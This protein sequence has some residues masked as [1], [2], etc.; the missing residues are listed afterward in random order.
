VL[1][2]RTV[3]GIFP[4]ACAAVLVD[5]YHLGADDAAIYVPA[6]KQASDPSLY[7]FGREFFQTQAGWSIVPKL[8]GGSSRLTHMPVDLAIFLWHIASI[9]LFLLAAW[10]LLSVCFES[11]P[12]RWGG[13]LLLAGCLSVPVAGTALA[14]MDPYVTARSLAAPVA[15]F[16]VAAYLAERR[17]TALAWLACLVAIHS[18]MSIYAAALL[19]VLEVMRRPKVFRQAALGLLPFGYGFEPAQ[20]PAREALLARTYFF[21]TSWAWYEWVGAIAPVALL[22]WFSTLHPRGATS[23]GT[24]PAFR[25]MARALVPY[26]VLFTV[27]ALVLASSPRLETFNRLQP[28]RAF[29]LLYCIFFALLGGLIGEYVLGRKLWRWAALYLPLAAG[30]WVAQADAY[31]SSPQVE[32]PGH[33]SDNAWLEALYWIRANTPKDAVFAL[34]PNYFAL[35]GVDQHGFRAVAERSVLADRLKDSGPVAL[36]PQLAEEWKHQVS[37][38]TGWEKFDRRDFER[39]DRLYPVTWIVTR[40]PG[41]GLVCPYRTPSLVVCH[42]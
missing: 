20:G 42:I 15:M 36:F 35:P 5:G 14:I 40:S 17:W 30:M 41:P 22:A 9:Y 13:V 7:P 4:I 2:S 32:W 34:D 6:I 28:M 27:A 29:H 33:A 18:Q 31:P 23:T 25:R 19:G 16:A 21:V 8:I 39:L 37:A 1:S 26:G 3:L 10:Q 11:A 24:M 38:Q 12:A